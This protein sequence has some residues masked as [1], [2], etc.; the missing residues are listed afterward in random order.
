MWDQEPMV[1]QNELKQGDMYGKEVEYKKEK[2]K[3]K[4]CIKA[5]LPARE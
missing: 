1:R 2:V 3:R 4:Q 5:I